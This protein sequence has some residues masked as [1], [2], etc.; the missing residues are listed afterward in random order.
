[1]IRP[2]CYNRPDYRKMLYVPDGWDDDGRRK[3]KLIPDRMSKDC[4]QWGPMGE[5]KLKHWNCDGCRHKP[6]EESKENSN[7]RPSNSNS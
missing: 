7:E 1:M 6:V 4:R 2:S 5:A 3:L